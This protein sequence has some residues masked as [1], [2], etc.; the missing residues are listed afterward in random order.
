MFF[1]GFLHDPFFVLD[2]LSDC[3]IEKFFLTGS[4]DFQFSQRLRNDSCLC[5]RTIGL[6]EFVE[7]IFHLLMIFFEHRDC[8]TSCWHVLP[9]SIAASYRRSSTLIVCHPM[10]MAWIGLSDE[11]GTG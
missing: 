10:R 6:L 3:R 11:G 8:V 5:C 7:K 2:L 9:Y 1:V 4:V